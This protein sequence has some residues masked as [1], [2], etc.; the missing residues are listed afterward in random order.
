M[1]A[2]EE[3]VVRSHL[4][5]PRALLAHRLVNTDSRFDGGMMAVTVGSLFVFPLSPLFW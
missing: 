2:G 4:S 5:L 3:Y 1:E